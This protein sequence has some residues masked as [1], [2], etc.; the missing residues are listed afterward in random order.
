MHDAPLHIIQ[1]AGAFAQVRIVHPLERLAESI[2][3]PVDRRLRIQAFIADN[4]LD[5]RDDHL[6]LK[7]HKMVSEDVR[8]GARHTRRH[9]RNYAFKLTASLSARLAVAGEFSAYL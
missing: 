3:N 7:H 5:R 8:L 4:V 6:I 9:V 2:R 1:I